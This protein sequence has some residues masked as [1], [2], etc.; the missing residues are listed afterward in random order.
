MHPKLFA[1]HADITELAVDAIVNAANASLLGGGGVDGA[2]HRKAGPE[3]LV[4][5]RSLRGCTTGEAKLTRA[6]RLPAKYVIHTVGPVWRGG[7]ENEA[8]L[9][10]ACYKNSL[11]LA[12]QQQ[13]ESVAFPCISSGSY[14]YPLEEAAEIAVETVARF[15]KEQTHPLA[16][17]FCC[18]SEVT[19]ALYQHLLTRC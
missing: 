5:C 12:V 7:Q 8:A 10:A 2:I 6:Y 1:I 11:R 9:L 14:G 4:E 16:V 15:V 17:T 18:F 3:L 19:L 13:L